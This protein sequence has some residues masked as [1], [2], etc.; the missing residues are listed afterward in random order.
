MTAVQTCGLA[1]NITAAALTVDLT[2]DA[3]KV[4]GTNDPSVNATTPTFTGRV[5]TSVTDWNGTVT[6]IDDTVAGR[7]TLASSDERRVGTGG[8]SPYAL[9]GGSTGGTAIGNYTTTANT[10][11]HALNVTAAALTVD[12]TTDASKVYG[13]NDPSVNAT[14]PTF[15][16]RV[17]TS[18]TDWNGTVTAIDDTV[19]GRVT[20]ASLTRT[21]GETVAGSPYAITGGSAGGTAIGNYTTTVNTNGHALNITA[22]ALTVDLTTD[23][24]K[25]Y[26]TN[27][28]SVNATTPTFT[29]RVNTSVTDWNGTV[30]AIDDTVAGRVTLASLTRTGGETVAGSPYAITGGSAGGT[31]IGN[32]TT[33]VNTNGHALAI[34]QVPLSVT[35]NA[36]TKTYGA[37]DPALSYGAAGLVTATVTDWNS[38]NTSINDTAASVLSGGLTRAPGEAVAGSPYAINQGTLAVNANYSIATFTGSNLT[39]TPAP[40]TVTANNA[41]RPVNQPD[42]PFSASYSGFQFGETPAA[43]TGTL[44][45]ATTATIGSPAGSYPITPSGQSSTNYAIS[46]VNG[47]LVVTGG[48]IPPQPAPGLGGGVTNLVVA[49]LQQ[50][51]DGDPHWVFAECQGVSVW[52]P[53]T[54]DRRNTDPLQL[55][56]TRTA[57]REA[58]PAQQMEAAPNP[59]P[60]VAMLAP[61]PLGN[62]ALAAPPASGNSLRFN[63]VMTAVMYR[64]QAAVVALLD[65]GWWVDRRDSNGLTPLMAAAM[66][67]D[68]SMTQLLLQRGADPNAR[69]RGTSV[70]DYAARGTDLQVMELLRRAGA[71]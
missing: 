2:T 65:R 52:G 61:A 55:A 40:L 5:N 51:G 63:D 18:V 4:Y 24:S 14:T 19:A 27:D 13:T 57:V 16:G 25:V 7:V 30:T 9:Q 71:R 54:C 49:G 39:I 48:G 33:T 34:T 23:A 31:A 29:G 35:A 44:N 26:G 46:Y 67:G 41:T 53:W 21:G 17:N 50:L 60:Q 32:Y 15:T 10:N 70:L 8:G 59:A 62:P 64:D 43:L 38:N 11:G 68:A 66:N 36:Q 42:P 45:L 47:T 69:V 37:A 12:P 22:A 6:A 3:S 20:L 1:I 28:P 56:M 58:L